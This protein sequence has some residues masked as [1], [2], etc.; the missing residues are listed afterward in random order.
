MIGWLRKRRAIRRARKVLR[1]VRAGRMSINEARARLGLR[2]I[3]P[4]PGYVPRPFTGRLSEDLAR[5]E[6]ENR[7]L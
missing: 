4:D 3:H 7:W 6:R 1:E 5:M 2:A